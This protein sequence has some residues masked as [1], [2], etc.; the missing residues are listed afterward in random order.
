MRIRSPAKDD[1]EQER[2]NCKRTS[3]EISVG[4]ERQQKKEQQTH[5]LIERGSNEKEFKEQTR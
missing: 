2:L 3:E 4:G 1:L 5:T